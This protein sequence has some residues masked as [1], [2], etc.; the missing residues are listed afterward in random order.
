MS[1]I[2]EIS[3]KAQKEIEQSVLWYNERQIGL[4]KKFYVQVQSTIESISNN[5]YSFAVR[6]Q[7]I[8]TLKTKQFPYLVHYL[9]EKEE[10]K[11]VVLSVLHSSRNPKL[12][13]KL[14]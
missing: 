9:I 1:F 12:W 7:D 3:R 2:L 14:V 4:G 11:I 5:P 6:Y 10:N 8:R 13:D